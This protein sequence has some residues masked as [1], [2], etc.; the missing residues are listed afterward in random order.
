ML[1]C[2]LLCALFWVG[3][4]H[5][6][7]G[8]F[9]GLKIQDW[10]TVA[11]GIFAALAFAG[12]MVSVFYQRAEIAS[13]QHQVGETVQA[14][15]EHAASLRAQATETKRQTDAALAQV[16]C[17]RKML[18]GQ[19]F[20]DMD[21]YIQATENAIGD[22]LDELFQRL[23]VAKTGVAAFD[24]VLRKEN[25]ASWLASVVRS[26]AAREGQ[27]QEALA[28]FIEQRRVGVVFNTILHRCDLVGDSVDA[29][30]EQAPHMRPR[31]KARLADSR[32][33]RIQMIIR[34]ARDDLEHRPANAA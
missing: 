23:G 16:D 30:A 33:K 5:N 3:Y 12:F 32:I 22:K 20:N 14:L 25:P 4:Q 8:F 21:L 9:D 24:E 26:K 28:R 7:A 17:Q 27:G 13:L 29:M 15:S 6:R 11:S 19:L 1:G 34:Y 18:A 10:A 31:L 2:F